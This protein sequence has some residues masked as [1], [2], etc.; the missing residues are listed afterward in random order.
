MKVVEFRSSLISTLISY[1]KFI[2]NEY[3][4]RINDLDK[5]GIKDVI[6]EGPTQMFELRSRGK[7]N[8]GI[9]LKVRTYS[10]KNYALKIRRIDSRRKDCL[11]EVNNLRLANIVGVGP[12]ILHYTNDLIL[13]ELIN[14]KSIFDWI[15]DQ[16]TLTILN[17]ENI[18]K[19]VNEILEQCYRLDMINLDHG[20]LTRIDSHI[21]ISN[22]N[23]ITIIDFESS[24]IQRRPANV[25]SVIQA[26]FWSGRV[27]K[28]ISKYINIKNHNLLRKKL[29]LYKQIRSRINFE[30]IISEVNAKI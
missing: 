29:R 3:Y 26:L 2:S 20:E 23:Q 15:I 11:T 4:K 28:Q 1:P 25:T 22:K 27:S 19:I 24:S 21:M 7:R 9:V 8:S 18:L 16:F 30:N 12:K 13:M 10:G 17:K 6:L 14:G 5:M